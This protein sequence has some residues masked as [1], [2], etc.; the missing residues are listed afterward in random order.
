MSGAVAA[1]RQV[2]SE[3]RIFRTPQ[4]FGHLDGILQ[5]MAPIAQEMVSE[6]CNSPLFSFE[7]TMK[8]PLAGYENG[9]NPY[10]RGRQIN[11]AKS[12]K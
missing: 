3:S 2:N 7:K 1:F 8:R 9:Y 6:G 5:A 10:V 4:R 12:S 11:A